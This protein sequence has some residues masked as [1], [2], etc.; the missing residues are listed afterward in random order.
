MGRQ[1][2]ERKCSRAG[3]V[4]AAGGGWQHGGGGGGGGGGGA[5][6]STVVL[7]AAACTRPTPILQQQQQHHKLIITDRSAPCWSLPLAH[8]ELVLAS[9]EVGSQQPHVTL[10]PRHH[11]R[12]GGAAG[13]ERS[14]S[15]EWRW[16]ALRGGASEGLGECGNARGAGSSASRRASPP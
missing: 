3:S 4:Q 13:E 1:E 7:A 11:C 6:S 5:G 15:G 12:E 10:T 14:R 9:R 16:E 2:G 8:L